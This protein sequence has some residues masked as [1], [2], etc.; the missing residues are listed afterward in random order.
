M[1][2]KMASVTNSA[3]LRI[4]EKEMLQ[5]WFDKIAA[6]PGILRRLGLQLVR[7]K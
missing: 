1:N 3:F 7:G 4:E 5:C 6:L 2:R